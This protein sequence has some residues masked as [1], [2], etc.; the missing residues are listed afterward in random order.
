MFTTNDSLNEI[1]SWPGM[2]E[3]LHFLFIPE[4]L[5]FFEGLEDMP[6][7]MAAYRG[8]TSWNSDLLGMGEQLVDA[9]NLVLELQNGTRN[10]LQLHEW[11]E[12]TPAP[13]ADLKD[14]QNAFL[15]TPAGKNPGEKKPA[16]LIV[17]GGGYEFVS[18]QNEG[19]PILNLAEKKGYVPFLLRYRIAPQTYPA[20]QLDLLDAIRY[21]RKHAEEWNIDPQKIAV[22][23]F[24][25]GGH[26]AASST[27][28]A[29]ELLPE[30]KPDALVLG[31]PVISL[32]KGVAHEGSAL[33]LLGKDD[34]D[35]RQALSVEK[36][37]APDFPPV[38]A[39]A[40]LDDGTVLPENT[41]KLE[42]ALERQG[43]KHECHY[44]PSG[45]HGC[46]L[47]YEK[48]AWPWSLKAFRFLDD[49]F[50]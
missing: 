31:Y 18:F 1:F 42:Q 40:C 46:G 47:A 36:R 27:A 16:L 50:H 15:I 3:W 38:F 28:L 9:A 32:E 7:R 13:E 41:R 44:Y 20:A 49:C 26:L 6:L 8:Q 22:C 17:P 43:V 45:G 2:K 5:A 10:A 35:L 11:K 14:P 12:W 34:A 39:W 30:G 37:I 33:A 25:A 19:V 29:A 48:S 21:I 24:S 4:H 23:G